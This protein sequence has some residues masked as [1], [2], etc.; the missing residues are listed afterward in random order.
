MTD[1]RPRL[2]PGPD[3][4]I[5]IQAHPSHVTVHAGPVLIA[6]TDKAIELLEAGHPP[7]LYIPFDDLNK[8]LIRSSE[9]HTYC[10]YKGEASYYDI[11]AGEG[12]T[13]EGAIWYYPHPYPAV[14]AIAGHIAFYDDRVTITDQSVLA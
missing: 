13:L 6:Q 1:T 12:D 2:E 7:V 9:Q 10:P 4:P 3:H 5:T 11:V 14:D 8:K